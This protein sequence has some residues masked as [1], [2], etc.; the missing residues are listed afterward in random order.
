MA[1]LAEV[2]GQGSEP[3]RFHLQYR[4]KRIMIRDPN[5]MRREDLA[6]K[7]GQG[8][9]PYCHHLQYRHK[10]IMIRDPNGMRP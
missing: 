2:Q 5:G 7:P 4:H 1:F 8:L 6:E 3:Y 10:R 9:E